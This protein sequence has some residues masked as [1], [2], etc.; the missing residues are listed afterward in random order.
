MKFGKAHILASAK[1]IVFL[2]FFVLAV[3]IAVTLLLWKNERETAVEKFRYEIEERIG[4]VQHLFDLRTKEYQHLLTGIQGF[5]EASD[6]VSRDGFRRYFHPT[7]FFQQNPAIRSVSLVRYVPTDATSAHVAE[8]RAQGFPE[9]GSAF[10]S[11]AVDHAPVVMIEPSSERNLH[12]LGFDNFASPERREVLEAAMDNGSPS[13]SKALFLEQGSDRRGVGAL[14]FAPVYGTGQIPETVE[15]RRRRIV[16]WAGIAFQTQGFFQDAIDGRYPDFLIRGYDGRL[17][18]PSALIF[19]TGTD[20]SSPKPWTDFHWIRRMRVLDREWVVEIVPLESLKSSVDFRRS[21]IVLASGLALSVITAL[22]VGL[23]VFSRSRIVQAYRDLKRTSDRL[24][25][26]EARY[27]TLFENSR[28]AL[29]VVDGPSGNIVNANSPALK[30]YGHTESGI[31]KMSLATLSPDAPAETLRNLLLVERGELERFETRHR[32][33]SGELRDVEISASSVELDGRKRVLAIV[34]DITERKRSVERIM[35]IATHDELTGLPNRTLLTDR[36][37]MAVSHANR[38]GTNVA[39]MFVDLDNFK[40]VNDSIG[41]DVGDVILKEATSRMLSIVRNEDT[42]ARQGGD[43]FIIVLSELHDPQQASI[44]AQ[45][46]LDELRRPFEVGGHELHLGASIGISTYPKDAKETQDL[47]KFADI[48]MYR[49]KSSGRNAYRFFAPDMHKASVERQII[50]SSLHRALSRDELSV[51]YQPLVR[52][53]TEETVGMECLI[54][55]N[56]PNLGFVPPDRF[57]PVAEE[58]GLIV[59]IGEKVIREVCYQIAE[60]KRSGLQ[61]PRVAINLSVRQFRHKTLVEDFAAILEETGT[62]P[63]SIGFEI[64]ESVLVENVAEVSEKL[65]RL[66]AL[67]IEISLD[68]FGT[69]YSSLS[70]LKSY[71]IKKIKIDRSFV[72]DL[73]TDLDDI[74][75]VNAIITLSHSLGMAVVAE[76]VETKLQLA[77]LQEMGC[78]LIQ[79][80][81][82]DKPLT[83]RE[84]EAR[85]VKESA[86]KEKRSKAQVRAEESD[87][88]NPSG[89]A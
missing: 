61:V 74:A 68:D 22:L 14:V 2:P 40:S 12:L 9:Y 39:V 32:L 35:E 48:A 26:S 37:A 77:M 76:G 6:A 72:S 88:P 87:L 10:A 62:D 57:I 60:W 8:M 17:G 21:S 54:R 25:V 71:P 58:T 19:E 79:G 44:V 80:Y 64:T 41:H 24:S 46:I 33:A 53:K 5:F 28:V 83:A 47:I 56:S 82:Y 18:D 70:Y 66:S 55:W 85:L 67:G 42:V 69:G 13:I 29:L 73:P 16:G 23:L 86:E 51:R 11:G 59:Q 89:T 15:E 7:A 36:L 78:D 31:R 4:D 38:I 75:I 27:R 1:A 45:K 50:V 3:G 63:R 20:P 65:K 81:Y 34:Q 84:M 49:A 43:E 52:A 30:Y